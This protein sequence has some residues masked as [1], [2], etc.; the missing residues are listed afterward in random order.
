M[1]VLSLVLGIV[2]TLW[3]VLAVV[4]AMLIP[5][6]PGPLIARWINSAIRAVAYAPLALIRSYPRQDRWLA[7]VA[8]ITVLIQLVVYVIILIFTTGLIV[9]GTTDL[10]ML[11]SLYQSGATLTTLGIVEPINVASAIVTFVAAFLGLV[12]IAIFIGYLLAIYGALVSRESLMARLSLIA[13]EPAWAPQILARGHVLGLQPA[14]APTLPDWIN[15]TCDLRMNHRVN[16]VLTS[17]R[18]T[19]PSRHWVVTL[20][21]VLDAAA[22]RIAFEPEQT[23]PKGIQLLTEGGVTL[24]LL[25]P[26]SPEVHNW[27]LQAR[28]KRAISAPTHAHA[29]AGLSTDEWET[30]IEALR[31]ADFP[32]PADLDAAKHRFFSIR[33]TYAP[34]AYALA[35][36]LHAVPAP[37][38]GSRSPSMETIWPEFAS[39]EDIK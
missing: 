7:G 1:R 24:A 30:G 31:M 19:T 34:N 13:G 2:L 38:S 17:F 20:I 36:L 35:R 4:H 14:E 33:S 6:G 15:W 28:I 21:A 26:S 25:N 37:W 12:I 27:D 10:S 11:N 29:D 23:D 8:P 9:Y 39:L 22:L 18:S 16:P 5:N 32:L 3:T